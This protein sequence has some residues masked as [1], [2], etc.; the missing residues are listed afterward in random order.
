LDGLL[1]TASLA[2]AQR[3]NPDQ[4]QAILIEAVAR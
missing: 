3:L 2:A 1:H 4:R